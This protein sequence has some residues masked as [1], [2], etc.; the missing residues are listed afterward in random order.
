MNDIGINLEIGYRVP[1][2]RSLSEWG[3]LLAALR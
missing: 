1:P 3:L 2:P